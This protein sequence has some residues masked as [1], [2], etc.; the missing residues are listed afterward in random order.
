VQAQQNCGELSHLSSAKA[1]VG[2]ALHLMAQDEKASA[3]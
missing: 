2:L 3:A 1:C